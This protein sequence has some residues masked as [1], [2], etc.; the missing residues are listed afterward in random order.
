L[1]LAASRRYTEGVKRLELHRLRTCKR[2]G[3]GGAELRGA[4]GETLVIPLDPV[5]SRQVAAMGGQAE[6][7]VRP[8]ADVVVAQLR[9]SGL[10]PSEIVIDVA[11]GRLRALVSLIGGAEP[12]VVACA[13]GEG[14]VLAI[15][16]SLPLY[17][18]DDALAHRRARG[19]RHDREGGAGGADTLH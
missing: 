7:D 11:D 19:A 8:L 16:G 1:T 5:Q 15:R 4:D 17:A 18:T 2:C 14:V 10:T 3:R 12:D 13:P 6:D 9:E